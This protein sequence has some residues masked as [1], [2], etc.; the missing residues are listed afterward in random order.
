LGGVLLLCD[1]ASSRLPP[2]YGTLG[3]SSGDLTRHIAYDIGAEAVT[4]RLA[5]RLGVPAILTRHSRLLIDC[6]RG[7]DDPTL[8]M[9]LS[10]GAVIPGNRAL[11]GEERNK[12]IERYYR[13]YHRAIGEAIDR[14][15]ADSHAPIL[16]SMHSFTPVW[17]GHPRPWHASVL[18]DRDERVARPLIDAL[19]REPGMTIGDNEP[20]TGRLK[21][22][23]MWQHGTRRGLAHAIIEIRQDLVLGA[24]GQEEW[25]ARLARVLKSLLDCP[26]KGPDLKVVRYFGSHAEE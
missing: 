1:H 22:D 20:Y 19:S 17:K 7:L 15:I 5:A 9:R 25:A 6:N 26:H 18:W 2:E 3:L 8:I 14:S 10:D 21:G 24:D 11:D 4:R 12:R 16:I 13:P 23:T